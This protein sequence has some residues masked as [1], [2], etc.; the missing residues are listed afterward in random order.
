AIPDLGAD[1][2][3]IVSI[4]TFAPPTIEN[5]KVEAAIRWRFHSAGAAR[6]QRAQR[7]VQPK[8]NG[9]HQAPRDISVVVLDEDDAIIETGFARELVH[10]LDK[11][12]AVFVARMRFA[13]ENEL[14]WPG[15][16]VQQFV[17]AIFV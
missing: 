12:F 5:A 14:N 15:G 9:L 17:Q 7:I 11:R 2:P 3:T 1:G 10:F 13:G 8:I 16:I 6:F 4:I